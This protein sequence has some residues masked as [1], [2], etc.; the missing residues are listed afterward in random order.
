MSI[1]IRHSSSG[2]LRIHKLSPCRSS[3]LN[4]SLRKR[5]PKSKIKALKINSIHSATAHGKKILKI[6]SSK[7]EN[8]SWT[9]QDRRVG[10]REWSHHVFISIRKSWSCERCFR[11]GPWSLTDSEAA[12]TELRPLDSD[13]NLYPIQIKLFY[14][15]RSEAA[16]DMSDQCFLQYRES[17]ISRLSFRI[18]FPQSCAYG[19]VWNVSCCGHRWILQLRN[20]QEV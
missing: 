17:S 2:N 6:N 20:G 10:A 14:P 3:N 12:L 8:G 4:L 5:Q 1:P 18:P 13:L 19:E 16:Q 11:K 9:L 15:D 7:A